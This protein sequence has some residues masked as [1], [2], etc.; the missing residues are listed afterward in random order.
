MD[1]P[2]YQNGFG[3][4]SGSFIMDTELF[5]VSPSSNKEEWLKANRFQKVVRQELTQSFCMHA[6]C[7]LLAY[8]AFKITGSK[9]VYKQKKQTGLMEEEEE[10]KKEEELQC[11]FANFLSLRKTVKM[12]LKCVYVRK[13]ARAS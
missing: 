6:L 2:G 12:Y 4:E 11:S 13:G 3:S 10:E 1:A 9:C 5:Q 8:I 7:A